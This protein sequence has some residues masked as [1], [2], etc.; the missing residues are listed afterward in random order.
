MTGSALIRVA[1]ITAAHGIRGEVKLRTFCDNPKD[2][3]ACPL[4][5]A[6]GRSYTLRQSGYKDDLLIVSIDGITTRND[7]ERLKGTELFAERRALSQDNYFPEEIVGLKATLAD[8]SI[9]GTVI[10][11]V[12]YGAGDVIE[13]TLTDGKTELLPLKSIFVGEINKEKGTIVIHPPEYIEV[14]GSE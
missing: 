10:Q 2:I 6:D 5:G 9:Y 3:F 8:G 1:M 13:L 14:R 12:N 4:T 7:A 11:L